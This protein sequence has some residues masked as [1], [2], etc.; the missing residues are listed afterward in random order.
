MCGIVGYFKFHGIANSK[1]PHLVQVAR[2]ELA[3]RGPDHAGLY[4]SPGNDCVLGSRRLSIIDLSPQG[5]QPMS[6]EDKDVWL[7]FNGEIYNHKQ[8]RKELIELGHRFRSV[9]D[10]EV[11]VHLYEEFGTGC[12]DRV[13]GIFSFVIY[14]GKQKRLFGARDRF[15]V[16]PLYYSLSS[17]RFA[18]ASE[19]KALFEFPDIGHDPNVE[20]IP[21]FLTFSCVPGPSTLFKDIQKL[22]PATQFVVSSDGIFRKQRFWL[23]T[24]DS[25][26]HEIGN[27]TTHLDTALRNAISKRLQ[28]DVSMGT[29]LSGGIDSSL[30]ALLMTQICGAPVKTFAVG[31]EGHERNHK[32]DLYYAR[33]VADVLGSD[34]HEVII[35]P[36]QFR[37]ILE[38]ELP[39]LTDDPIGSPSEA[40]ILHLAK[41]V[42]QAGVTVL[43]VGEGSDEL[44]CGYNKMYQI[45]KLRR[46]F[47][48]TQNLL[49]R[50]FAGYLARK[51]DRFDEGFKPTLLHQL[52]HSHS[53]RES[54]YWGHGL[55]FGTH[56]LE[57]I[58]KKSLPSG[59]DPYE[60]LRSRINA[61]TGF[62]GESCLNQLAMTDLLLQLPERLLM[63]L[64]KAT[65]RYGVEARE[66]F[67]DREVLKVAFQAPNRL[68]LKKE[69]LK[70]YA[71]HKLS[72]EILNRPKTGFPTAR[73][74]FLAPA[75]LSRIRHTLLAKRF[76][77]FAG[78]EVSRLQEWIRA[79][80]TGP[81]R[82][83]HVWSLY[84][85]SLW[86]H[87]WVERP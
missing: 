48:I 15:G 65:M 54:L 86:Y 67:L 6:N 39:S 22:E 47:A 73:N 4:V 58:H 70:L 84:M 3:H 77:E 72:P 35:T 83:A 63:R 71:R 52:L 25:T 1:L 62:Q 43:Q 36:E 5:N 75:V 44:F 66:P 16:K 23:P 30:I 32:T 49:P 78:F 29:T 31:Y 56:D 33:K 26:N 28:S 38:E 45:W 27:S 50:R 57:M 37:I 34:H 20:E 14:D 12:L 24:D 55:V 81:A 68:R 13:D 74:I 60:R 85:L 82:F 10:T 17:T 7:V 19:P 69:L 42:R 76:V 46:R 18:F 59:A 64:D 41:S 79:C 11:L 8:L 80:E 51:W 2:D 40:A 53:R 87:H 61:A 21:S 9:A